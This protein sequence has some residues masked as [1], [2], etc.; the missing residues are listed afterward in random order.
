M[1]SSLAG[2][3][4]ANLSIFEIANEINQLLDAYNLFLAILHLAGDS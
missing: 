3:V 2:L 4:S 1:T